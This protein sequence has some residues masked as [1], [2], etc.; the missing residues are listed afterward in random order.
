MSLATT[1]IPTPNPYGGRVCGDIAGFIGTYRN[2][3]AA[4]D[5]V[6]S[7]AFAAESPPAQPSVAAGR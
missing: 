7:Y 3:T 2:E 5:A 1:P 6:T 4:F